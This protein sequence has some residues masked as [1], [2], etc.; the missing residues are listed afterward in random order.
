MAGHNFKVVLLGEGNKSRFTCCL[1]QFRNFRNQV[2]FAGCVGKTSTVLRYVENKFESK[3]LSTLQVRTIFSPTSSLSFPPS[4]KIVGQFCHFCRRE[5]LCRKQEHFSG[6]CP[7]GQSGG[8]QEHRE[9]HKRRFSCPKTI[10]NVPE[11][12][13]CI[14]NPTLS[15]FSGGVH[16]Q[17]GDS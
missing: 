16:E 5:K 3:H 8:K 10:K 7:S 14:E 12:L 13:T 6:P 11:N 9:S 2:F 1:C 4:C 15:I 17:K